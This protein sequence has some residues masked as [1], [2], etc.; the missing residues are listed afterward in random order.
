MAIPD[1]QSIMLPVLESLAD[2]QVHERR[3]IIDSA[4]NKFEI[5]EEEMEKK[6]ENGRHRVFGSRVSWSL[7]YL[8]QAGL[9]QSPDRAKYQITERG[10]SVLK[11]KPQRIT[12]KYLKKFPE[13]AGY[14]QGKGKVKAEQGQDSDTE[15]IT[16]QEYIDIGY[17]KIMKQLAEEI[18]ANVL[19]CSSYFFESLVI[20]LLLAMGY[21]GSRQEAGQVTQRGA[22]GGIDGIIKEDRLG[23]DVIYVQAKR[24][25][26]PVGRPEI[27][28]FAGALMGQK[29]KKGV[30]ITTSTFTQ[31]AVSFSDSIENKIVL[32]D[33]KRLAQLMIEHSIGVSIDQS[34]DIKK[35]DS[36]YFLEE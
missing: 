30:F 18:L 22:D 4:A 33:G 24:W 7:Q 14:H 26:A 13:F 5:T 15:Q 36:D 34:Y 31:E 23:L 20:D 10:I 32:I 6:Y 25:E 8:K 12:A 2:E 35:I 21:G 9:I 19:R 28:K 27:Q 17:A 11:E 16:P 29:A 1:F 3:E